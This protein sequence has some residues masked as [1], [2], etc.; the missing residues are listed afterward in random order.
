MAWEWPELATTWRLEDP[1]AGTIHFLKVARSGH[2]PTVLAEAERMR[3]ARRFV[4][5]PEV[6]ESG[7]EGGVDWLGTIALP[8]TDATRHPWRD[9]PARLVPALARGLAA[10][11]PAAPAASCP[12]RFTAATALDHARKRVR[13]GVAKP[14]DLH[15]EYEHLTLAG[16]IDELELLAPDAEDLVVAHGDYCL[17]NILLDPGGGITGYV[18]LGE[19]GVADRW[20]DIAVGAWSVTWNLGPGWEDVFYD[21]YGVQ[22]DARRIEFYRILYDLTS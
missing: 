2:F 19:L 7:S 4:S 8:G 16:A 9:D 6:I 17:P 14:S 20:S 15:P 21:A 5:V 22:P 18:D 13:D 3:W 11:P 12:F 10:F 1:S